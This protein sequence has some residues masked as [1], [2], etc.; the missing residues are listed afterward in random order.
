[1]SRDKSPYIEANYFGGKIPTKPPISRDWRG[2]R[3]MSVGESSMR[4]TPKSPSL[5]E[6]S[7]IRKTF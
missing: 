2:G 1:M 4:E 6:S 7:S 5:H 3:T